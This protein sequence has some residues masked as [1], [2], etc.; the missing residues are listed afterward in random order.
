MSEQQGPVVV[1]EVV[2]IEEL[3]AVS[4]G[5]VGSTLFGLHAAN[6]G[7]GVQWV[8]SRRQLRSIGIFPFARKGFGAGRSGYDLRPE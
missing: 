8:L 5:L 1:V 3:V 4:D 7:P 6:K 2:P